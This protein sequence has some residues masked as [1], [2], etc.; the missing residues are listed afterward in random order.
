M[1]ELEKLQA[2]SEAV[3]RAIDTVKIAM[4]LDRKLSHDKH[5][6]GHFT[7]ALTE[8][9]DIQ[10]SLNALQIRMKTLGR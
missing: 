8:L 10:S 9:T 4:N 5:T 3:D 6:N 1:T 2:R 7:K